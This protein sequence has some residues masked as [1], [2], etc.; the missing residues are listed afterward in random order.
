MN[1]YLK[2]V[3]V[4]SFILMISNYLNAQ[5]KSSDNLKV[6]SVTFFE[7][8]AIL[9]QIPTHDFQKLIYK[10]NG[11]ELPYRLLLPKKYNAAEKYPVVIT[12]HNS[13]R[14]GNDNEKQLEPLSRIWLREEI[15]SQYNC[16]VIAPQFNERS[17]N[18]FKNENGV[19]E[20][21]PG[22]DV[23][24]VLELLK[25]IE[26]QYNIDQSRIYLVGYSMGAST[27]QNLMA[28]APQ[29]FAAMVSIAA[30]PDFSNLSAWK[31]KSILLI[32]GQND[33]ENPYTGSSELYAKL[34]GNKKLT[35]KTYTQ[36]DHNNI[37]IPLLLN[38]EIPKWL[39]KQ[40]Q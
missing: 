30:V 3:C 7:T 1:R 28:L 33:T 25:E 13:T 9:N 27:A 38:G 24:L 16:F 22:N 4:F 12:F 11:K 20:S 15:Y 31:N 2:T 5:N 39:F 40:H 14:I 18:Y 37:T 6:D 21:K 26:T 17:S 10:H 29:K 32:H 36:L 23:Q 19:L 34:S 35:F 8:R